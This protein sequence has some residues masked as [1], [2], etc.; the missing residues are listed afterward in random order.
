MAQ[1]AKKAAAAPQPKT[2][3]APADADA[4]TTEAPAAVTDEVK[5]QENAGT[6][7]DQTNEAATVSAREALTDEATQ[8]RP[9]VGD[10]HDRRG[11][12]RQEMADDVAA[13]V[14]PKRYASGEGLKA[15]N[16]ASKTLYLDL[17]GKV[18][19]KQPERGRLLTTKGTPVSPSAAKIIADADK[20]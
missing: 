4:K 17:N 11:F 10:P 3:T 13:E 12:G 18:T 1:T 9:A 6:V 14:R 16:K 20:K 15:G 2:T 8:P 7:T 19:E 5:A